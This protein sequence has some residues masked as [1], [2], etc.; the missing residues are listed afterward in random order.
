MFSPL[1]HSAD[2]LIAILSKQPVLSRHYKLSAERDLLYHLR[3]HCEPTVEFEFVL[4]LSYITVPV[5]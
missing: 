4:T 3:H 5:D 1:K 2:P